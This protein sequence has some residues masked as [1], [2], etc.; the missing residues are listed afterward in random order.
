MESSEEISVREVRDVF[1]LSRTEE[2]KSPS[3]IWWIL[4]GRT[5][6]YSLDISTREDFID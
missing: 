1:I 3:A 6:W 2:S 4:R 5:V